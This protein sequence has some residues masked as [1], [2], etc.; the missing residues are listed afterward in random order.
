MVTKRY[1][2]NY[3]FRNFNGQ[4]YKTSQK[5]NFYKKKPVMLGVS[6][7]IVIYFEG[8]KNSQVLSTSGAYTWFSN[9]GARAENLILFNDFVVRVEYVKSTVS[10][11][12][13]GF[14][15][16]T[17]NETNRICHLYV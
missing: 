8:T 11:P 17:L 15:G 3:S 9:M 12:S 4:W 7:S 2:Y 5:E 6:V 16:I 1:T 14:F 13:T 10:G